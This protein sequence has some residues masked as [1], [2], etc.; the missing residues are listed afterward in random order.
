MVILW[1]WSWELFV[2]ELKTQNTF[3]IIKIVVLHYLKM[4]VMDLK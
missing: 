1:I 3:I 4:M 2:E